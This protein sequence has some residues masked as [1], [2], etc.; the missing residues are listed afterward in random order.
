M[1]YEHEIDAEI[2]KIDK[3]L[4]V[5]RE[6]KIVL[7]AIKRMQFSK[8]PEKPENQLPLKLKTLEY[9]VLQLGL[10][11]DRLAKKGRSAKRLQTL[12]HVVAH[13]AAGCNDPT[14]GQIVRYIEAAESNLSSSTIRSHLTRLKSDGL[15]YFDEKK[16]TWRP[17]AVKKMSGQ[18]ARP[19]LQTQSCR[20]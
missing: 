3:Q 14:T 16:R 15:I 20:V 7:L 13:S 8:R 10:D 19:L 11:V 17:N 4:A 12:L 9:A 2:A 18:N 5:L 1:N 6:R